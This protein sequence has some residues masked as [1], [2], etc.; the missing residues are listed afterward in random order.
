[1]AEV[2]VNIETPEMTIEDTM[3]PDDYTADRVIG[4]ILSELNL[5]RITPDG[6]Q[7]TYSLLHV[8]HNLPLPDGR[9]LQDSGVQQ[10][11]TIKLISSNWVTP[12]VDVSTVF[13]PDVPSD[14]SEV[15]VVLSVLDLNRKERVILQRDARV[16]EVIPQIA[17]N[18]NLPSRDKINEMITYKLESKALGRF[19]DNGETL[20]QAGIPRL[21]TLALHR[22]EIAGAR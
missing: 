11:D 4:E 5:P 21:D 3:I 9:T 14:A 22:E 10:G 17:V 18:Y 20:R 8:N 7:I 19:L 15:E 13:A 1:V 6:Q 16:G 12:P 2:K